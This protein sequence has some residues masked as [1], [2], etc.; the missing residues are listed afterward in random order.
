M[1][2][3]LLAFIPLLAI[4]AS[5]VVINPDKADASECNIPG[6]SV[7]MDG[8]A[9]RYGCVRVTIT[10]CLVNTSK[11][12]LSWWVQDTVDAYGDEDWA[13]FYRKFPYASGYVLGGQDQDSVDWNPASGY[14]FLDRYQV[15]AP[16]QMKFYYKFSDKWETK[17]FNPVY[18]S[19][20]SC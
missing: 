2:R 15:G 13:Q 9:G 14:S 19:T 4:V 12:W 11:F 1:R 8:G 6:S 18:L 16:G 17:A 10:Y 3:I 20:S 5:I 7:F